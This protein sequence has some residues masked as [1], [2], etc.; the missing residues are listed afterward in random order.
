MQSKM[1]SQA[2]YGGPRLTK[3]GQPVL[4]SLSLNGLS[5]VLT[6][7]RTRSFTVVCC[8]GGSGVVDFLC[9][10]FA[11][12]SF[13]RINLENTIIKCRVPP[14]WLDQVDEATPR[15]LLAST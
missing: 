12:K 9:G 13:P 4:L 10:G 1:I 3:Q 5:G 7:K 6:T 11:G 15:L 2:W 14:D 8:Y